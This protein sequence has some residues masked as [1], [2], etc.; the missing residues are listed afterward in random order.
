MLKKASISIFFK[1]VE[2]SKLES[3]FLPERSKDKNDYKSVVFYG[4]CIRNIK[5][6]SQGV[7]SHLANLM[8]TL[9]GEFFVN[10]LLCFFSVMQ[11]SI[12]HEDYQYFLGPA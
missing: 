8:Y 9:L 7:V 4:I 5:S 12:P 1:F 11:S 3:E 10:L 2:F 6:F